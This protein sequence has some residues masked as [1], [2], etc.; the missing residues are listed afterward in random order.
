MQETPLDT[1]V[2]GK[3]SNQIVHS[4]YKIQV[5]TTNVVSVMKIGNIV[6][7]AGLKLKLIPLPGLSC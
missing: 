3:Y 7:G 5:M 2:Q 4:L 1:H 6:L